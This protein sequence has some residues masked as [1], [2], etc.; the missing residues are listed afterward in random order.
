[1]G[2]AKIVLNLTVERNGR[3]VQSLLCPKNNITALRHSATLKKDIVEI[4]KS[5]TEK[6]ETIKKL[7]SSEFKLPQGMNEDGYYVTS[8]I[9]KKT[10]K[11]VKAYIRPKSLDTKYEEWY[12]CIKDSKGNYRKVG[13]REFGIDWDNNTITSGIMSSNSANKHYSG[14]GVRLHQLGIER[15][16]QE[17]FENIQICSTP[18]AFPFHSKCGFIAKEK[19]FKKA[20]ERPMQLSEESLIQWKQLIRKQPILEH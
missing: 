10:G 18:K 4:S 7:F 9:S 11:P 1:M 6:S 15:M 13:V 16:M 17:G 3:F 2:I 12:M 14:I 19:V 20:E 8:I 5:L